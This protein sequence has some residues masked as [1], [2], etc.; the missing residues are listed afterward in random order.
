MD[1]SLQSEN[2]I[3]LDALFKSPVPVQDWKHPHFQKAGLLVQVYRADLVHPWIHG[4]KAWKLRH[5]MELECY[6]NA[7]S[8]ISMGGAFSNHLL[9]LSCLANAIGKPLKA[10][11]RGQ[12]IEWENNPWIQQMRTFGAE[13]LPLSR[14][15]FRMMHLQPESWRQFLPG[16][17]L[18]SQFIPLGGSSVEMLASM[19]DWAGQIQ[20]QVEADFWC[21]P[22]GTGGTCVGLASG[23]TNR[24]RVLAVEAVRI[25]GGM[26]ADVRNRVPVQ[27][28]RIWDRISWIPDY[29]G[30]GFGKSNP[31]LEAFCQQQS[32]SFGFPLE[33]VYSGKAF[34]AVSDLAAKG[35]FKTGS[36]VL[37]IHTGGVYPWNS[38]HIIPE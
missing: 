26:E 24:T 9:A 12:P 36:R 19:Q 31:D 10:F 2:H 21:L 37:L 34:L 25:P 15:D 22:V 3:F 32:G 23:L 38:G 5:L 16:E 11:I 33:P 14:T 6:A 7:S 4:N 18:N 13:I 17:A 20:S 27:D 28:P 1:N 8:W 30:A 29:V 35:Y